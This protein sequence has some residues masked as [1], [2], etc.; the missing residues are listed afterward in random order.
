MPTTLPAITLRGMNRPASFTSSS[1]VLFPRLS[2]RRA[3]EDTSRSI[4]QCLASVEMAF[5]PARDRHLLWRR[6]PLLATEGLT[7]R[8][9][10][11]PL[12]GPGPHMSNY[13]RLMMAN[14]CRLIFSTHL[15][16][17]SFMC[18]T[19]WCIDISKWSV[20]YFYNFAHI[21]LKF[22]TFMLTHNRSVSPLAVE[23]EAFSFLCVVHLFSFFYF[24]S[25]QKLDNSQFNHPA[26][27]L[28]ISARLKALWLHTMVLSQRDG[29]WPV[30]GLS[31]ENLLQWAT[32]TPRKTQCASYIKHF[33]HLWRGQRPFKVLK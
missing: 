18:H 28:F 15:Y 24:L 10:G 20:N 2:L 16:I 8:S 5:L 14:Y 3:A 17:Y 6:V 29:G 26:L 12:T 21:I 9:T 4:I 7:E 33:I 11:D 27:F 13:C 22:D 30:S 23:P 19:L 1:S 25:F 32:V 31:C